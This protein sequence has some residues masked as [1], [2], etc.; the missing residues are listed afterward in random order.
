MITAIW[1]L[2]SL[3]LLAWSVLAWGV[4]AVLTVD[5]TWVGELKDLMDQVPL[6]HWLNQWLPGW[7]GVLEAVVDL[8]RTLL[9]S[10]SDC[11]PSIVWGLWGAGVFAVLG[12]AALMH[13]LVRAAAPLPRPA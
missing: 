11:V 6:A 13:V 1:L 2:A 4:H 7:Q 8:S 12:G 3:S 9:G 10:V 5:P